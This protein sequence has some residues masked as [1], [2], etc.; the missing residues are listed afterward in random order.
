M[1]APTPYIVTLVDDIE[2]YEAG[3]LTEPEAI[4]LFQRLVDSGLVWQ[5]QG[6]YG[7]TAI[8]LADHGLITLTRLGES[9]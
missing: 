4:A 3:E 9:S 6:H 1:S 7:R 2:R 8:D 5:L